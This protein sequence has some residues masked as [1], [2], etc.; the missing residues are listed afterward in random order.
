MAI[1][2]GELSEQINNDPNKDYSVLITLKN[3]AL[4]TTLTDKGKF[5][6]ANK[7]FSATMSGR[8]IQ[9][10]ENE[11]E[12]EAIEPDMEMGIL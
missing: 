8:E 3:D 2:S 4:P 6:M 10:L 7:I 1:I 12:I 11:T 9:K 5:V